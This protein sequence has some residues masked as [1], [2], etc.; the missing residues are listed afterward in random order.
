MTVQESNRWHILAKADRIP[1][2]LT[3]TVVAFHTRIHIPPNSFGNFNPTAQFTASSA[4]SHLSPP[5]HATW[6][7]PSPPPPPPPSDDYGYIS[8]CE[9]VVAYRLFEMSRWISILCFSGL[10]FQERDCYTA[11]LLGLPPFLAIVGIF[12]CAFTH[13]AISMLFSPTHR[14]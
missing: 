11:S 10:P 1:W 13:N 2:G 5:P 3:P 8:T 14:A 12:I 9:P 4:S 6:W 7:E